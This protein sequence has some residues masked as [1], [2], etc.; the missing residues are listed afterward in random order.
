MKIRNRMKGT[1]N[2]NTKTQTAKAK[3]KRWKRMKFRI[4][5]VFMK[6]RKHYS[7]RD[8]EYYFKI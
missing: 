4:K 3:A 7:N 6:N 8:M 1:V 2:R 5:R